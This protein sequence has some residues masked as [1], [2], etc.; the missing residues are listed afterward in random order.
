MVSPLTPPPSSSPTSDKEAGVGISNKGKQRRPA[1]E[2]NQRHIG[3]L[4][5]TKARAVE[6]ADEEWNQQQPQTCQWPGRRI[7]L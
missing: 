3:D 1:A 2:N 4:V 6:V 5:V 7:M